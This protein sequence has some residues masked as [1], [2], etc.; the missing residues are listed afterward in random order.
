MIFWSASHMVT[1]FH[2]PQLSSAQL[3]NATHPTHSIL[4]HTLWRSL[5][6]V[7][8]LLQVHV[9]SYVLQSRQLNNPVSL[10]KTNC[11]K[12]RIPCKSTKQHF[13]KVSCLLT[14]QKWPDTKWDVQSKANLLMHKCLTPSMGLCLSLWFASPSPHIC[15]T[16]GPACNTMTCDPH[17]KNRTSDNE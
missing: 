17:Q 12:S 4:H 16:D 3:L 6:A 2:I 8:H 11:R 1:S 5:L 14:E 15:S 10:S 7:M 13:S 9:F